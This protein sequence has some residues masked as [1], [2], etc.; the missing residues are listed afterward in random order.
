[1]SDLVATA[2]PDLA[3]A[4]RVRGRLA[5]AMQARIIEVDDAVIVTREQ[6]GTAG[7]TRD[8]GPL[9]IDRTVSRLA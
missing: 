9:R 3:T 1:M 2:Y 8:Q 5:E 4:E 7:P 6:D